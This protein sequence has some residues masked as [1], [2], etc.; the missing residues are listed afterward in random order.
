MGVW[1]DPPQVMEEMRRTDF[2]SLP[3]KLAGKIYIYMCVSQNAIEGG[4]GE[5]HDGEGLIP[6]AAAMNEWWYSVAVGS[7]S[8]SKLRLADRRVVEVVID[9]KKRR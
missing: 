5:Q 9:T 8:L 1:N 2:E 6:G 3:R 4:G 7:I